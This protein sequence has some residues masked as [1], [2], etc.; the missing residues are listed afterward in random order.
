MA[1]QRATWV[2]YPNQSSTHMAMMGGWESMLESTLGHPVEHWDDI[3]LVHVRHD[4]IEIEPL[5]WQQDLFHW[6]M[7][8][9]C[10]CPG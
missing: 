8:N 6:T 10:Q 4:G 2:V 7:R 5:Q 9:K 1:I 3:K